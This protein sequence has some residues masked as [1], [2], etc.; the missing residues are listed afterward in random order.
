M[1]IF[2]NLAC[3]IIQLKM[4]SPKL[5]VIYGLPSLMPF[6]QHSSFLTS[7]QHFTVDLLLATF[8]S[9]GFHG[10]TLSWF[11][12]TCRNVPSQAPLLDHYPWHALCGSVLGLV[13]LLYSLTYLITSSGPMNSMITSV[14]IAPRSIY[15]TLVSPL[16]STP[17]SPTAP[18]TF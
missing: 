10:T 9:L 7:A 1:S 15:P 3:Q 17:T 18:L 5:P 13:L 14:N 11:S 8:F 16:K 4:F 12:P 2:S 6:S